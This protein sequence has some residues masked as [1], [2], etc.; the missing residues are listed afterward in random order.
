MNSVEDPQVFHD[1]YKLATHFSIGYNGGDY[2]YR[3]NGEEFVAMPWNPTE[4]QIYSNL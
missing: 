3:W 1:F 4:E 2:V